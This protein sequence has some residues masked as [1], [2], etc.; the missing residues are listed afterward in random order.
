LQEEDADKKGSRILGVWVAFWSSRKRDHTQKKKNKVGKKEEEY[1]RK[2]KWRSLK[3][4][5]GVLEHK[6]DYKKELFRPVTVRTHLSKEG[7][8]EGTGERSDLAKKVP[9]H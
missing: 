3:N 1:K 8:I 2:R 4:S 7:K 5:P 9:A 6:G